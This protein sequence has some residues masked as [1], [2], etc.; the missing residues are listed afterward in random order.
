MFHTIQ[1]KVFKS[2]FQPVKTPPAARNPPSTT[3]SKVDPDSQKNF[4]VIFRPVGF[5]SRQKKT[6]QAET[7]AGVFPHFLKRFQN[8]IFNTINKT[9][10]K[11]FK[12]CWVCLGS[13][14]SQPGGNPYIPLFKPVESWVGP[15]G[16][17]L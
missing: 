2:N 13:T 15:G 9:R 11:N 3:R 14:P 4:V 7:I 16:L 10:T 12:F 6:S 8:N 1:Q 17:N 5:F